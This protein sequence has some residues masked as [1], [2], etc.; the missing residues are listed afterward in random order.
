MSAYPQLRFLKTRLAPTPSGYLHWGNLYNFVLTVGLARMSGARILLRIDDLDQSRYREDYLQD[1]FD[2]LTYLD[3]PWD[4]GPRSVEE[5]ASRHSRL[6]RLDTYVPYLK[7]LRDFGL[8]YACQ[9][10]H[11]QRARDVDLGKEDPCLRKNL[12]LDNPEC[13]WRLRDNG[14]HG[15]QMRE[16]HQGIQQ[17]VLPLGMHN[18]LI[19][20]KDGLPFFHL[21]SLV[22]DL[23]HGVNLIVRGEDLRPSSLAQLVLARRIGIPAFET[24]TFLHHP[25]LMMNEGRKLSKSAQDDSIRLMRRQGATP[26]SIYRELARR[27]ELPGKPDSWPSLAEV[28]L[29]RLFSRSI[30]PNPY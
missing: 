4:E 27:L 29:K 12:S 28:A 16:L 26:Q 30:L 2:T 11:Q 13:I 6:K 18:P 3:L 19:R 24:C 14:T 25:L 23:E 8:L 1:I 21:A 7:R 10:S 22:D 9:C 20:R 17:W 15:I 5:L